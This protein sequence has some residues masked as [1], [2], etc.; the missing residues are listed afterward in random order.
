[1]VVETR[2]FDNLVVMAALKARVG[3]YLPGGGATHHERNNTRFTVELGCSIL[4][5]RFVAMYIA[6]SVGVV[7]QG[8]IVGTLNVGVVV[9]ALPVVGT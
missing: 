9:I 8:L 2:N 7:L 3:R 4:D 5:N 6:R 1:L